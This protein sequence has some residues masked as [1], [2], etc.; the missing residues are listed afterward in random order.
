M[1]N[2][3]GTTSFSNCEFVQWDLQSKGPRAAIRAFDGSLILQGNDFAMKGQQLELGSGVKKAAITGNIFA[4]PKSWS[5]A[6]GVNAQ[7]AANAFDPSGAEE[8]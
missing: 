8:L 1:I 6:N 5:V 4:G 3:S 2:G 7:E